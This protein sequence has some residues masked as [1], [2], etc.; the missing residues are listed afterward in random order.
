MT[1]EEF[2]SLA[3]ELFGAERGW[4]SRIAT[5]L[6]VERSAITRWLNGTRIPGPVVAAMECWAKNG[7]PTPPAPQ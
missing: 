7:A 1:G 3:V 5:A 2:R 6:G 4:Q